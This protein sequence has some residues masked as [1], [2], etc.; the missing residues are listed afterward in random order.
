MFWLAVLAF[1]AARADSAV[2]VCSFGI[3][4]QHKAADLAASLVPRPRLRCSLCGPPGSSH[5]LLC[6]TS[7]T[8]Q[9]TLAR[10]P[11]VFASRHA[12]P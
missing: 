9:D 7:F 2:R 3:V 4:P 1:N 8:G 6:P 10:V 11:A 5:A 12:T